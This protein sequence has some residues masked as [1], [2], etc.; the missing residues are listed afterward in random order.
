MHFVAYAG[1]KFGRHRGR[2]V[3]VLADPIPGTLF[4]D[5]IADLP[6]EGQGALLRVL[7][8]DGFM[9]Q[10]W[11]LPEPIH[12]MPRVVA[13]TRKESDLYDVPFRQDLRARL[14]TWVIRTQ[15]VASA[16]PITCLLVAH[17]RLEELND[18]G[19]SRG[20]RS[21]SL[22]GSFV[23]MLDFFVR[24]GWFDGERSGNFRAIRAAVDRARAYA[25]LEP[26]SPL[27]NEPAS[28]VTGSE[29]GEAMQQQ[30]RSV[31]APAADASDTAAR[32]VEA[33]LSAMRKRFDQAGSSSSGGRDR[34]HQV[35]EIVR[36]VAQ[37][38][39]ADSATLSSVAKRAQANPASTTW[40]L[41]N[42]LPSMTLPLSSE[43]RCRRELLGRLWLGATSLTGEAVG[44]AYK[45]SKHRVQRL[46][47][48][49]QLEE[50]WP[51]NAP[52]PKSRKKRGRT[53]K[54]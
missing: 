40:L 36:L 44:L 11:D 23:M 21:L 7:S 13:A 48:E 5:E 20:E 22:D 53:T 27:S 39:G 31:E 37:V 42:F 17:A 15:D 3:Y 2:A 46:F 12:V 29:L 43:E 1:L 51:K 8:G 54:S 14:D 38:F 30:R 33:G 10:G 47:E 24:E 41:E 35:R 19:A 49:L 32:D 28:E 52:P 18:E 45:S 25:L 34:S 50:Y 26:R 16:D 6:P 4:L 9:P